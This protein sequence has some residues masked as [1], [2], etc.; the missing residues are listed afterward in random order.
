LHAARLYLGYAARVNSGGAD[1]L[2]L[3]GR[4]ALFVDL[5][6]EELEQIAAKAEEVSFREGEWIIRQGDPQSAVYVIADG[7]VAVVIDDEDRRVL[8]K[9]SFFGE[10]AVLLKEPASASIV[11]RTPVTCLVIQGDGIE[12]FLVAHPLVMYRVLKAEARRLKTASEW[13]T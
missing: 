6:T 9:G 10:V 7:E 2:D 8:S 4:L 11:T 12:D 1:F 5:P 13:R 3:L